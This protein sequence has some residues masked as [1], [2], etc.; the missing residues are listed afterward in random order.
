MDLLDNILHSAVQRYLKRYGAGEYLFRQGDDAHGM[1]FIINGRVHLIAEKA[2]GNAVESVLET[3][4]FLG[5]RVLLEPRP[6]KRAFAAYAETDLL[7][8]EFGIE[9]VQ[10]MEEKDPRLITDLL[11]TVVQVIGF[12]FDMAN[13]L[14]SGLRPLRPGGQLVN[15]IR[16]FSRTARRGEGFELS[17]ESLHRYVD[18]D[19]K[20]IRNALAQMER[21]GLLTRNAD[22]T[23]AIPD[24]EALVAYANRN[25]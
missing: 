5:E 14:I 23:Y 17:E 2:G 13:F 4:Q 19:K 22:D 25:P 24:E 1:Y 15:V 8:L 20:V 12:R 7:V 9:D 16:Y 11:K 3:G 6:Y 21:E 10:R 18:I